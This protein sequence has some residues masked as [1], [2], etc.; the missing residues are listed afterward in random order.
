MTAPREILPGRTYH[1]SRRTTQRQ[2]LLR[3]DEDTTAIIAYCLA[4]A[5]A[6]HQLELIAWCAMS[7]HYHAIVHD[8]F[9]RLPSF[10]EHLHKML[11][12]S[13]NARW[14]RWENL[15]SAEQTC[16][17]LLPTPEAVFD[18]VCY[19]LANPTTDHLV[20]RLSDW[21]G[22]TS[23]AHLDGRRTTH[24]RPRA[25]F[26]RESTM[27]EQAEL[28]VSQPPCSKAVESADAWATRVR[29]AVEDAE[30]GAREKRIREGRRIFGRKAVLNVSHLET[31]STVAPR[32]SLR[33]AV[34]CKDP[35]RRK[36][37]LK[38]LIDFRRRYDEARRRYVNG[39]HDVEFPAGTYQL[40][41]WGVRCAPYP[42]PVMAA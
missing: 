36:E 4:E 24:K 6:R 3:P 40:R 27:P 20:D 39:E 8:P 2:F 30:R 42:S 21:P 18:K 33:P 22:C 31:P 19:V 41:A 11:A 38:K 16:V 35:S 9:G 25:F 26:S 15:W 37:E 12:R 7:N 17:T 28:F 13:L 32:Q 5:A 14:Q 34:A 23:L 1:L 10:I 29:A